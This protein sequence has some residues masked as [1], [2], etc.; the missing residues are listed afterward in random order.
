MRCGVEES[1]DTPII[2]GLCPK[3]FVQE[4]RIL[5]L[6]KKITL[7]VCPSCGSV[8]VGGEWIP[9]RGNLQEALGTYINKAML[10]R[11]AIY[12]G[13]RNVAVH[14]LEITGDLARLLVEG[15]YGQVRLSQ[16]VSTRIEVRRRLCPSC[17]SVRNE[18]FE[19]TVQ[20]RSEGMPRLEVFRR[21]AERIVGLKEFSNVVKMEET[22]EGVDLRVRDQSSARFI[23]SVLKKEFSAYIKQTWK[24]YGYV[25]GKRH[26]KLTISA[27]LPGV[28]PG[29]IVLFGDELCVVLG[30]SRKGL[31]IRRLKDG[32][33]VEVRRDEIWSKGL[34]VLTPKDYAVLEGRLLNYEGGKA[35]VQAEASG[36]IYYVDSP[37]IF[38]LGA[39]VKILIYKG[40]PHLLI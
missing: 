15:T 19:A 11:S 1:E 3:H 22:P 27:R 14:V 38:D 40:I 2:D 5:E 28:L 36:N 20:I 8:Y 37:K 10:K 9:A 6:P 31:V 16:E 35:V 34:N 21:V 12:P 26:G 23:A 33:R 4:R 18:S 7:T 39:R 32:K 30:R 24:D 13:F 17:Q 29:D 25:G